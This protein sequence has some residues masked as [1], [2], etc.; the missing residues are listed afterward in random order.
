MPKDIFENILVVDDILDTGSTYYLIQEFVR[1][2]SNN[3]IWTVLIDKA[4]QYSSS[5]IGEDSMQISGL[6]S[7]EP[8]GLSTGTPRQN[9]LISIVLPVFNR[10]KAGNTIESVIQ[11][12]FQDFELIIVDDGSTLI[13]Q[14]SWGLPK[15]YPQN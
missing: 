4:K 3:A 11:Q 15:S 1:T 12:S 14:N 10:N 8:W 5:F 6:I 2:I 13:G 7:V 9:P